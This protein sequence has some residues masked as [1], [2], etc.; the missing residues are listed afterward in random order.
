[1]ANLLTHEFTMPP[2]ATL[3]TSCGLLVSYLLFYAI[4]TSGVFPTPIFTSCFLPHRSVNPSTSFWVLSTQ[5]YVPFPTL[6]APLQCSFRVR[7]STCCYLP[8]CAY[9]RFS[10][11]FTLTILPCSP[12]VSSET[13][14]MLFICSCVMFPTLRHPFK[15]LWTSEQLYAII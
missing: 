15:T 2:S 5:L 10:T 13:F 1:M 3:T 12:M 9:Q 11:I 8:V 14:Y 7:C 6:G 4:G